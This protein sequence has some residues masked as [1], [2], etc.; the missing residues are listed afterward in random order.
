VS[1]SPLPAAQRPSSGGSII[2]HNIHFPTC[3]AGVAGRGPAGWP[4]RTTTRRFFARLLS[5]CGPRSTGCCH[6]SA[7]AS[8]AATEL[9]ALPARGA[10]R[11]AGAEGRAT[12]GWWA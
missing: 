7:A 12:T 1:R 4:A 3:Q 8:R 10:A 9:L 11:D 2:D 6:C 5:C